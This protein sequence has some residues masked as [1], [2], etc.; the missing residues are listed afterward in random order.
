[1]ND[2][3]SVARVHA[4][5][6]VGMVV[7]HVHQLCGMPVQHPVKICPVRTSPGT[8][9][10]WSQLV[11]VKSVCDRNHEGGIQ[12]QILLCCTVHLHRVLLPLPSVPSPTCTAAAGN[13]LRLLAALLCELLNDMRNQGTLNDVGVAG[14][15]GDRSGCGC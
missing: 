4:L 10:W 2:V 11:T 6:M 7:Q 15:C 12:A 14:E 3:Y 13:R 8:S 1:M 9:N 5:M